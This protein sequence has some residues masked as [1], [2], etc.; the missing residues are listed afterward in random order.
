MTMNDCDDDREDDV[1]SNDDTAVSII[2]MK[3]S[4]L[5]NVLVVLFV[6]LYVL[7]VILSSAM[8]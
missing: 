4:L 6:D 2:L 5:L 1:E 3:H 7:H 8:L